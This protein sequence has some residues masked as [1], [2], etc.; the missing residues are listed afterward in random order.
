MEGSKRIESQILTVN[1]T[2]SDNSA[3]DNVNDAMVLFFFIDSCRS[4]AEWDLPDVKT[5]VCADT[6]EKC[7]ATV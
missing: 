3:N 1:N 7:I 2:V 4:H 5:L 6:C